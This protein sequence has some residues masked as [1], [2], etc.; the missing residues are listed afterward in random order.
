MK[1]TQNYYQP[2]N[3]SAQQF[4]QMQQEYQRRN[5]FKEKRRKE[6]NE[7]IGAGMIIGSTIIAY[8]L[9]QVI[10]VSVLQV[11]GYIELYQ[12]SPLFQNCFNIAA[13]DIFSLIIPFGLMSLILR[14]RYEGPVVPREKVGKVKAFA[15]ISLGMGCCLAANYIVNFVIILFKQFGYELTKSDLLKTDNIY[16]CIAVVFSTAI[17]PAVCEEFAMR[18]CTMGAL[19]K[20]GKPFAVVAVS[21]VF[22][23]IHGNVIQFVFAFI[24]GLILGYVTIV[25]DSVIPA[26]LIHGFNNGISVVSDIVSYA[27]GQKAADY[28]AEI[29]FTV[30]IALAVWGL[31]YLVLKKQL[32]PKKQQN[33]VKEPYALSFGAKLLCLL[34]GFFVPFL[35]LIYMTALTIQPISS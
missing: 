5:F 9:I 11:L 29:L 20:Y 7:L 8:L 35:I 2:P 18:C 24:V 12:N 32:I 10:L 4:Y 6:R 34:P 22:G 25:T 21:I 15:W 27:A 19:R 3:F 13:I 26:M 28:A 31:V 16:T 33:K 14:K 30:W 23:L 17:A 1:Q